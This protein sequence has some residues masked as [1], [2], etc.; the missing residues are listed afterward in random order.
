MQIFSCKKSLAF[1]VAFI[2]FISSATHAK[3]AQ[4]LLSPPTGTFQVGSTFDVGLFLDTQ[5]QAVNLVDANLIFPPD[6]LQLVSPTLGQSIFSMWTA[7]PVFDNQKGLVKLSGGM[8]GGLTVSRGLIT[9]LTFRV[10]QASSAAVIK[11]A[12]DST[13]MANDGVGTNILTNAQSAVYTFLLPPPEGPIVT[14]DTNP[15]QSKWYSNKNVSLNWVASTPNQQFSYM[16]S[17][18]PIDIPDDVAD[19]K[20]TSVV[21]QNIADGKMYFHIKALRNG[22]WGGTTHF[23]INTDSQ[24]PAAFEVTIAPSSYTASNFQILSFETTDAFSGM[25]HY[26]TRIINLT[27][28]KVDDS[29]KNFFVESTSPMSLS[30]GV[31]TYDITVR[32]FNKVGKYREV[33]KRLHVVTPI[34]GII[35]D[36]GI[37]INGVDVLPWPWVLLGLSILITILGYVGWRVHLWHIVAIKKKEAKD[38]PEDVKSQLK[39]LQKYRQKYGKTLIAL[40]AVGVLVFGQ[41]AHAEQQVVITPPTVDS[42]AQNISNQD[43]F[44]V[45]GKTDTEGLT[46]TVYIENALTSETWSDAVTSAH[47]GDWFY[48]SPHFLSPGTYLVWTQASLGGQQSP[49][50]PQQKVQVTRTALQWGSSRLSYEVLYLIVMIVLLALIILLCVYIAYHSHNARKKHLLLRKEVQ[51]ANES[52]RRG[53]AVLKNDIESEIQ[54]MHKAKLTR[55]FSLEESKREEQLLQDLESIATYTTKEIWEIDQIENTDN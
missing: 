1:V 48:K 45:G 28:T 9:T 41:H 29:T 5:G 33:V 55:A 26:E 10:K 42:V 36:G 8:P 12:D 13:V 4:L 24:L 53:F 52:I 34:F 21:Y 2:V 31:G 54:M 38:L 30:L 20:N 23:E 15:D 40:F 14:S 17:K 44:Y 3:A 39:D 50:S 11:F 37:M 16:L 32:A 6:T 27:P 47:N 46:V 7:Q 22:M 49:P 43:I 51:E 18:N 35:T 19:G 25:D